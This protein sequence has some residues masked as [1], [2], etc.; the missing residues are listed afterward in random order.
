METNFKTTVPLEKYI[1]PSQHNN[2]T[3]YNKYSHDSFAFIS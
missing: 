3:T 2:K 1:N